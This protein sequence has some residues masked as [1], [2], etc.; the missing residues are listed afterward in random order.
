MHQE[1]VDETKSSLNSKHKSRLIQEEEDFK[2]HV[3]ERL[4]KVQIVQKKS[5]HIGKSFLPSVDIALRI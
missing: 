5:S 3:I 2:D 1:S 4:Q